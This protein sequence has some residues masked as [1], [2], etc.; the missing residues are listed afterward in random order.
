[1]GSSSLHYGAAEGA[2]QLTNCPCATVCWFDLEARYKYTIPIQL[3]SKLEVGMATLAAS[4]FY[5]N[6]SAP[7]ILQG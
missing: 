6:L 4:N 7:N 5:L 2:I 1:M 3:E